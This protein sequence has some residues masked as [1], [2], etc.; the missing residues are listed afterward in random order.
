MNSAL[1]CSTSE[2]FALCCV[3]S[4][5]LL[6]VTSKALGNVNPANLANHCPP[7]MLYFS[8]PKPSVVPQTCLARSVHSAPFPCLTSLSGRVQLNLEVST[9]V[10]FAPLSPVR[11]ND[12]QGTRGSLG[13]VSSQLCVCL[14]F[15][16]DGEGQES[17]KTIVYSPL[18]FRPSHDTW[19]IVH[20][21]S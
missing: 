6:S 2:S 13:H 17:R 19:H 20:A 11:I 8:H 12:D 18:Y 7:A 3:F 16:I 9:Q 1:H 15:L 21:Y 4:P 10:T 14:A 5:Q